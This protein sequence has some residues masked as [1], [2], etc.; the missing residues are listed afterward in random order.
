MIAHYTYITLG[1]DGRYYIGARSC[2]CDPLA[3]PYMGS[4]TDPTYEPVRK[5]ILATFDSREEALEHEIFLHELRQVD[6]NPRYANRSRQRSTGFYYNGVKSGPAN[7][8]YGRT[9]S[10]EFKRLHSERMKERMKGENNP[11]YGRT[12]SPETVEKIR[13]ANRA[14]TLSDEHR[15]AITAYLHERWADP[16]NRKALSEMMKGRPSPMRGRSHSDEARRKMSEERTGKRWFH[17]PITGKN[18]RRGPDECPPGYI[19]GRWFDEERREAIAEKHRNY[20]PTEETRKK[21]SKAL[22]GQKKSSEHAAK[23]GNALRGKKKSREHA[24]KTAEA[25]RGYKWF[26]DPETMTRTRCLPEDRPEGYVPGR[27]KKNSAKT[28]HKVP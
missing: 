24:R 19:A 4:H 26:H 14:K 13:Q 20:R 17:D 6:A 7:P 11:F 15:A 25:Q 27:G 16:E 23:I 22:R 21:Q 18:V 1:T 28:A 10:D 3:D 9:H 12:H 2:K 5:R 8:F